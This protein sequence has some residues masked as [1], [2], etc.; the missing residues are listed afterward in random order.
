MKKLVEKGDEYPGA[1]Y[2]I[3]PDGKRKKITT[4]LKEKE[5][6]N[7]IAQGIQSDLETLIGQRINGGQGN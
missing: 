6:G 3:R 7:Q 5:L 2:V 4:E 1:N